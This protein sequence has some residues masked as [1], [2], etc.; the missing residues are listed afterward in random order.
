MMKRTLNNEFEKYFNGTVILDPIIENKLMTKHKVYKDDLAYALADP[1]RLIMK[2]KQ[3]PIIP[4]NKP[5]NNGKLYEILCEAYGRVLFII[6]RLFNDGNLY[7]ITSYWA[8]KNLTNV[9]IK[10]SEV[11]Y[12]KKNHKQNTG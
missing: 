12:A 5:K 8:D 7:I 2:P 3:K 6:G 4:T 9:Y 11:Y 10:E 1:N